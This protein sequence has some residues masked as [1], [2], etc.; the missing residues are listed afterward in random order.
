MLHTSTN[1]PFTINYET[2]FDRRV[3]Q[4]YFGVEPEPCGRY[5]NDDRGMFVKTAVDGGTFYQ[6]LI[7]IALDVLAL[8][9]AGAPL[10]VPTVSKH[11]QIVGDDDWVHFC[12]RLGV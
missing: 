3:A 7:Q 11:R 9:S 12:L 10:P 8:T 5:Y 4:A 6:D 1:T 2:L